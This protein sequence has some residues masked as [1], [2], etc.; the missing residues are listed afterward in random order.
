MKKLY[1]ALKEKIKNNMSLFIM[2]HLILLLLLAYLYNNIVYSIYSGQ[3]GVLYMR[4]F[5][6]TVVDRVYG[7]GVHFIFPWDR[8][9]IYNT[10]V[11]QVAHDFHVLTKNGLKIH[12]FISIRYYPEYKLLGVLHQKVGP[13]YV[14]K[15][16]IP[17]I[18]S[19][20]RVLIGRLTAEEVY[21]TEQAIYEKALNQAIEQVAQRF[22]NVD[23]VIIKRIVLPD[24][25]EQAIQNKIEQ[26]HI[27]ESFVFRIEREEKEAER[28]RIEAAGLRDY[29]K[30]VSAS[31]SEEILQWKGIQ[32]TL[33]LAISNNSKVVV[34]GAG[35]RG[36][37]VLGNLILDEPGYSSGVS[38][39]K[40]PDKTGVGSQESEARSQETEVRSQEAGVRSQE[41]GVRSQESEV[42]AK[43]P[44]N[45]EK[46]QQKTTTENEKKAQTGSGV[47]PV[48][49]AD[50][51]EGNTLTSAPGAPELEND[52]SATE[53][54]N[55][56]QKPVPSTTQT[57]P[58]GN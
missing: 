29:N 48:N 57:V 28:K 42:S 41:A 32:A 14:E 7:E 8:M 44:D 54:E 12:L 20:L 49:E 55:D 25:V 10:R 33:E 5:G 30:I 40:K 27:A 17:E 45:A 11:Q 15:V 18:E 38:E 22:V 21:T 56:N 34:V 3:G 51:N 53:N 2:M 26:K 4:F 6:G 24:L 35:K 46:G 16:V 36:L 23:N 58:P 39:V 50:Q 9:Y 37:P 47:Q 13:A 19:V 43:M 31:L 52:V 1:N